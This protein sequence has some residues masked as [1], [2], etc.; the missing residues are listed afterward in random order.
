MGTTFADYCATADAREKIAAN[1]LEWSQMLC[2]SLE[3]NFVEE[4]IRRQ[5]FFAAGNPEDAAY[6][7]KRIAELRDGK[8]CYKFEIETGRKYYKIMME[9]ESQSR[10]VHAFVDKKTGELYK[11][12]SWKSPAKG[13]RFD[14]RIIEERE[15]VFKNCDW[16]GGYL[17]KN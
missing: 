10:S 17:Y 7:E 2:L 14:L 5:K 8:N 15:F 4:S 9:T 12:A 3:Q 6:Y 13:V 16:A 1:V 11:A